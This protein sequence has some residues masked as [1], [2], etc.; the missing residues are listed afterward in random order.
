MKALSLGKNLRGSSTL[1]MLL[2]FAVITLALVAAVDLVFSNRSLASD[3]ESSEAAL[4]QAQ[5]L[6]EDAQAGAR[7]DFNLLNPTTSLSVVQTGD[8]LKHVTAEVSWT[9]AGRLLSVS[10]GTD[11]ANAEGAEDGEACSS[12]TAGDWSK[13][14]L[15]SA[16]QVGASGGVGVSALLAVDKKLYVA[17]STTGAG[18]KDFYVYDA[19]GAVP[20]LMGSINANGLASGINDLAVSSTTSGFYIYAASDSGPEVEILD[21]SHPAAPAVMLSYKLPTTSPPFIAGGR[22]NA[23]AV[24]NGYL[25]VGL[26]AAAGTQLA[27][28]DIGASRSPA[29]PTN[30]VYAGGYV[31]GAGVSD[32]A[33][34]RGVAYLAT[35]D[36]MRELV[37]LD[38]SDPHAP[39]LLGSYHPPGST[40]FGSGK[41]LALVGTTVY[42]ARTYDTTGPEWYA[43]GAS[44]AQAP[45]KISSLDIGTS[46]S[47]QSANALGVRDTLAYIVARDSVQIFSIATS[48]A[49][50]L[51]KKIDLA[52]LGVRGAAL[53][54]EGDAMYMG[55]YRTSTNKGVVYQLA[56]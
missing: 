12:A 48:T 29:S 33:V 49:P 56:P 26:S 17:A 5:A 28:F 36:N 23:V 34:R 2:A 14:A 38:V 50:V 32:I 30:P 41:A 9:S 11:I 31:L 47:P 37:M 18:T 46:S 10:L 54:C 55:G 24:R 15:G 52:P 45:S 1:E 22:A 6:L 13:A 19:S 40:G 42:E 7:F 21:V 35:T 44:N 39:T 25:Y 53:A 3:I 27:I 4:S 43:I 20:A 8:Y 16:V 51:I